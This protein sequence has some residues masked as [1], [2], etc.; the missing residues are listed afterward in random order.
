MTFSLRIVVL[1]LFENRGHF[2]SKATSIF[3]L[4]FITISST[5]ILEQSLNIL[6]AIQSIVGRVVV[7]YTYFLQNMVL[8]ICI[9]DPKQLTN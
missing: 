3:T 4:T 1:Y 2:F 5:N 7:G 8:L 9:N 6:E